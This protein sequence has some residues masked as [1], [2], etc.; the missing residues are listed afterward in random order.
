[1]PLCRA[2]MPTVVKIATR[3]PDPTPRRKKAK[4]NRKACKAH[5]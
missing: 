3:T 4:A 1:V 5:K 2:G